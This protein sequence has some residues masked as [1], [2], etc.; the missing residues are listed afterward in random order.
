M[1]LQKMNLED[2]IPSHFAQ[3]KRCKCNQ[4]LNQ[5][6]EGGGTDQATAGKWDIQRRLKTA[7]EKKNL[8]F[9]GFVCFYL[10]AG[11]GYF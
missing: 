7:Q 1:T 6:L 8:L 4:R 5:H 10:K 2:Q 11:F 3:K 9:E